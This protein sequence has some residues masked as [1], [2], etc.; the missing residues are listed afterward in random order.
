MTLLNKI[1][2]LINS[3]IFLYLVIGG[4]VYFWIND[5]VELRQDIKRLENNQTALTTNSAMQQ[6]MYLG[7]FKKIHHKEDS[8]AKL[9]GLK[10]K[11]ITNVIVNNYHYKDTTIVEVPVTPRD[12]LSDTLQFI[13]PINCGYIKGRITGLPKDIDVS[14]IKVGVEDTDI[15]DSLYTYMYEDYDRFLGF[16]WKRNKRYEAV[17]YSECQKKIIHTEK[18]VKIIK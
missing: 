8:I 10:P 3:K 5:R 4:L 11:D 16:L 18:N 9:V 12:S 6:Q 15:K 14:K 17:T 1:Q 7:E 13:S 2:Q